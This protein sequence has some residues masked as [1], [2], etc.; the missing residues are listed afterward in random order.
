MR[1]RVRGEVSTRSDYGDPS[2]IVIADR[3]YSAD[4]LYVKQGTESPVG[5]TAFELYDHSLEAWGSILGLLVCV[6]GS[7]AVQL[8]YTDSVDQKTLNLSAG[9]SVL[10]GTISAA[11]ITAETA[12]GTSTIDYLVVGS[13]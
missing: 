10:L 11:D 6:S 4:P 13:T 5:T 12:S 2:S 9:C 3:E 1:L 8:V 7:T